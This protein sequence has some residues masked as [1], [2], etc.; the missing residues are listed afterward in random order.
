MK[1]LAGSLEEERN[2][3]QELE[4][5]RDQLKG[6]LESEL[7]LREKVTS[8]RSQDI[9]GLREKIK[10]LEEQSFMKDS[11]AQQ[12]KSE[13]IEK[14][15]LIKE[16]IAILEDKCK[17]YEELSL[18]TEKR[19]RQIDQL[20]LSVKSRDDAFTDLNNKHRA[21]LSQVFSQIEMY[22]QKIFKL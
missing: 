15:R 14:E 12:Y 18:V 20:R 8:E 6:R 4:I 21:L 13:L 11:V 16:K 1:Q 19:K 17:A 7:K 5:E 22:S 2:W 9:E 3:A 10:E